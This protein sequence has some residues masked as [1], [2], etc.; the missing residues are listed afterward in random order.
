MRGPL[1]R[2]N[3]RPT[4]FRPANDTIMHASIPRLNCGSIR[5]AARSADEQCVT[6][7]RRGRTMEYTTIEDALKTAAAHH[8]A[9]ELEKAA[10]IYRQAL[11]LHPSDPDALHLLGV[12]ATQVGHVDAIPLLREAIS[13]RPRFPEAYEHLGNALQVRGEF[14]EAI[15]CYR[16]AIELLPG[17]PEAWRNLGSALTGAGEID[18]AVRC[19]RHALSLERGIP[20]AHYNLANALQ[21]QGKGEEAIAE[22]RAAIAIDPDFAEAHG[23]LAQALLRR[24]ELAEGYREYEWRWRC[25]SFRSR[26]VRNFAQPQ[27]DGSDL[28]NRTILLHAEQGLGDTIQMVRFVPKV[29][30]RGGH[31]IVECARPLLR[32]LQRAALLRD[33]RIAESPAEAQITFDVH[34]P[35]MSLPFAL[36]VRSQADIPANVPYLSAEPR[37]L[38][39]TGLK[40]GFVWSGSSAHANDRNRSIALHALAPLARDGVTYFSLQIGEAAAEIRTPPLG[41][42]FIDMNDQIR[43]FADTAQIVAGLDLVI[44][45]DTAVAHLAG[46]M[47]KRAWVL[48]PFVADCRWMERREDSPWY[49]TMRL[50]RQRRPGDWRQVVSEIGIALDEL[51]AVA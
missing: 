16:R 36:G 15:S 47:G 22:F 46:A 3:R 17:F 35:M 42:K 2:P 50:F 8:R 6:L 51:L 24:G 40:V 7:P 33:A 43:D 29:V 38:T 32:L 10:T 1:C 14:S 39:A 34:M 27:W 30:A 9:G 13:R 37:Q 31:V 49:P 26:G 11:K 25:E 28:R 45:V 41:M 21:L 5:S 20:L 18:E 23:S 12:V 4:V 48:L 44:C 19:C